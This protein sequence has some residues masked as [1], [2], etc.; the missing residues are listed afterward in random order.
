MSGTDIKKDPDD[1]LLI[2]LAEGTPGHVQVEMMRRLK[3]SVNDLNETISS[4]AG[5]LGL[6]TRAI[7]STMRHAIEQ[8]NES[9]GGLSRQMI[10]LDQSVGKLDGTTAHYSRVLIGL[11][12]VILLMTGI[13]IYLA[14]K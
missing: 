13:Q 5:L 14:W 11:T 2:R 1:K 4:E 10:N 8:I 6:Q 12:V 7:D 3:L 9:V